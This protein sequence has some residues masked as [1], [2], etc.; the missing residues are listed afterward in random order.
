MLRVPPYLTTSW[1]FGAAT[2]SSLKPTYVNT[3]FPRGWATVKLP[4]YKSTLGK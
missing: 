3:S 1:S 2:T 4:S